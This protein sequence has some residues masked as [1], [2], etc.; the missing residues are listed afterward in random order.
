MIAIT[1]DY[2]ELCNY[3][4][5]RASDKMNAASDSESRR[6]NRSNACANSCFVVTITMSSLSNCRYPKKYLPIH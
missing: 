6:R 2:H 5:F 3:T 4:E 1:R